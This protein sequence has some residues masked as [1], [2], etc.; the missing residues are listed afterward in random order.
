MLRGLE[1]RGAIAYTAPTALST[2]RKARHIRP[3]DRKRG[4]APWSNPITASEHSV[5][6][7]YTEW[8]PTYD[9]QAN[10]ILIA[11]Q[12]AVHAIVERYPVGTAPLA[13]H[14][15]RRRRRGD[16]LGSSQA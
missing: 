9:G 4:E 6:S 13:G 14:F 8:A 11:E 12:A 1:R 5:V 10:P 15:G 7:G 3:A 2:R 16:P